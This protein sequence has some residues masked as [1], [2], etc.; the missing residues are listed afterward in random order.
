VNGEIADA[1]ERPTP[2]ASAV[3]ATPPAE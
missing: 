2:D 3:P 1:L